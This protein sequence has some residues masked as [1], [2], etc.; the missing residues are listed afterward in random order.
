[1]IWRGPRN[2]RLSLTLWYVG[3]MTVMFAAYV[4][5]VFVFVNRNLSHALDDHLRDDFEWAAAMADLRPDGTLTWFDP[6]DSSEA[7]SPW[8]TVWSKGAVIFRTATARRNPLPEHL[9]EQQADHRIVSV[10]TRNTTV[11]V[12]RG[13]T[14]IFDKDLVLA[15]ARSEST[16]KNQMWE[17]LT[18]LLLGMPI[19]IAASGVG[20]YVLAKRALAPI[21]RMAGR[22]RTITA[23]RLSDRLPV[24]NA[25]DEIGR[26]ATVFNDTLERLE[27]SFSRMRQFTSDVSHELR[28]PLTAM[29]SVGEVGLR[30]RRDPESYRAV[31][32]SML[33]EIDRL[34]GVIDTLLLLSRVAPGTRTVTREPIDLRDLA[35][36]VA[37][38]L[39]VLAEE[40]QQ[41][42]TIEPHGRAQTTGDR[43]M[44]RQA[45]INLLDN[46][47]KYTPVGG[48]IC[49][50]VRETA[51]ATVLEVQDNGPGV[52]EWARHRIFD[53]FYRADASGWPALTGSGLGLSI[54]RW[55]VEANGGTLELDSSYGSGSIFRI[56]LP[57]TRGEQAANVST[58]GAA[59]DRVAAAGHAPPRAS[60]SPTTRSTR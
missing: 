37:T 33:E 39:G 16:M 53:R 35:E 28:T 23:E 50:R 38:Q 2:V 52:P 47:I 1:M 36:E 29:K 12:L 49:L 10:P 51:T 44:L 18:L 13:H 6:E 9:L 22:A 46:A 59:S 55:A 7:A 17:L 19:G 60:D 57:S 26:L 8:L 48:D 31:I 30:E 34:A 40:K 24:D 58:P 4:G 32:S 54:S 42:L 25:N 15:V 41:T 27:S 56:T 11:R 5:I 21:D 20:G 45:V 43:L 3:A 14:T